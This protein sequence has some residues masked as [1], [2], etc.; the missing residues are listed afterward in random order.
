MFK[1]LSKWFAP[2]LTQREIADNQANDP[3]LFTTAQR[4]FI[5]DLFPKEWTHF[6]NFDQA[7]LLRIAVTMTMFGYQIKTDINMMQI[8]N[9]LVKQKLI[10]YDAH[11]PYLLRRI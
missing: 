9:L 6:A 3:E 5:G 1:F 10:V 7:D 2:T 11:N 4:K 8:F